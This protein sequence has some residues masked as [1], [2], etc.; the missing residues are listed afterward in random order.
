MNRPT[1]RVLAL[2]EIL[3]AGGTRTVAELADR[4]GVD[5]RTVRRYIGHLI[6]LDVPVRSVRG[7]YG[8]YRLAPGYRMPPLMLTDEEAL[9]VLLGLVAGRRAGLVTTSVAAAESAAAKVRRVL[10]EALGRRLD[11]L[12]ATADFTA[13]ARPVVV[14]GTDVLLMFAEA[15]RDRRPVAIGYT[16]W[17]G[18][19]S[20]RTVHPYG[21]VAHSGRWYVTGADSASGEVRMFRLDRI[22][23]AT[24]LPG[25]FEVPEGFDP[26]ARVLSGLA[27]VPYLHEVSLRVRGTVDQV[28]HR[29]PPGLATVTELPAGSARETAQAAA[30][31]VRPA[32]A[33][34]RPGG[35]TA[36]HPRGPAPPGGTTEHTPGTAPPGSDT[37]DTTDDAAQHTTSTTRP[38]DGTEQAAGGAAPHTGSAAQH[39][40]PPAGAGEGE[41]GGWVRVRLRAERL[42]WVPSVLAW[43]DLPFVIE[44]P[45]ALRDHVHA[46]AR[47]LA[48]GADTV[49]DGA[50]GA[51]TGGAGTGSRPA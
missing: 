50:E 2:L 26:A 29:L 51:R 32:G 18:R 27:G 28:R 7:R 35:G 41:G 23:T 38:A 15:A 46:L 8:G 47:R 36:E 39:A 49:L 40:G 31:D 33:D 1:A 19:R 20:E 5:E 14:P 42:E 6:D 9:A 11:A 10:P 34:A 43:L 21:I 4:L 16:G 22:E 37:A 45:D 12:L 44:Y 30:G 3:Q 24:V 13:P 17:K 25:S 48:T